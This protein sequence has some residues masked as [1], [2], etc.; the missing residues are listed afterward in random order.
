LC[1]GKKT[2]G[3]ASPYYHT[4]CTTKGCSNFAIIYYNVGDYSYHIYGAEN[5]HYEE[6]EHVCILYDREHPEN[7]MIFNITS[8]YISIKSIPS[9]IGLI[10]LIPAFLILR[11][12]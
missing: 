1:Y 12:K 7:S 4:I 6:G 10:F 3:V 9:L 2:E 11:R 5:I 8:I